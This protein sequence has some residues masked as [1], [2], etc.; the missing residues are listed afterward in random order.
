VDD[1]VRLQAILGAPP[2]R[3]WTCFQGP[4]PEEGCPH[5]HLTSRIA[6]ARRRAGGGAA[7]AGGSCGGSE[8]GAWAR[9]G[10]AWAVMTEGGEGRK[11]RVEAKEKVGVLGGNA[12]VCPVWLW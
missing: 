3:I 12:A 11:G 9:R 4:L 10:D 2:A 1:P 8:G 7:A 6:A 5:V